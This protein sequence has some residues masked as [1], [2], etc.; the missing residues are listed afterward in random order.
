MIVLEGTEDFS[1]KILDDHQFTN[2]I[3]QGC[4]FTEALLCNAKFSSCTFK[5]C[6]LSLIKL[7]G[8]RLQDC[9]S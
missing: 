2:Y 3:F 6:N 9:R 8:C 7:D 1:T 5:N 4:N